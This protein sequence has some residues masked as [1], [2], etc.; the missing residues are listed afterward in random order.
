MY[1]ISLEYL[2]STV[3]SLNQWCAILTAHLKHLG[4]FLKIP[5]PGP[6]PRPIKSESLGVGPSF[7]IFKKLLG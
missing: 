4:C 6:Y 5:L 1:S 2:K 3:L 7:D